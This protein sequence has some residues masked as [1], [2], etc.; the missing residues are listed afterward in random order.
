MQALGILAL[1]VVLYNLFCKVDDSSKAH[2]QEWLD[3][4]PPDVGH[5]FY[6]GHFS[7]SEIVGCIV[8]AIILLAIVANL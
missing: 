5:K 8:L 7:F 3:Q 1:I 4:Q 6:P 2:R